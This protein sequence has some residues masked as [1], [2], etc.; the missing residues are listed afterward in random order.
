MNT[1]IVF[2]ESEIS[3]FFSKEVDSSDFDVLYEKNIY[4]SKGL[5][6]FSRFFAFFSKPK[7]SK[8]RVF[9]FSIE[10]ILVIDLV[11]RKIGCPVV[12]L[13]NPIASMSFKNKILFLLYVKVKSIE[14][15][16]FDKSDSIKYNFN[17]HPQI[18]SSKLIYLAS[19]N[20]RNSK[21]FFSGV[22]KGR[23]S[24]LKKIKKDLGE[25]EVDFHIVKD[26]KRRYSDEDISFLTKDY[27]SFSDYLN[28]VFDS[29]ILVDVSQ[30]QQ[31]GVTLRVIEAFLLDKKL[32][33]T[34]AEVVDLVG[35]RKENV[36]I[37]GQDSRSLS[38]F[39]KEDYIPLLKDEKSIY[40]F[41]RLI[42]VVFP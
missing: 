19:R 21:A 6:F 13:W 1:K 3:H 27:I 26:K 40:T 23:L 28:R 25:V 12:W 37:Y 34:N 14:V 38:S 33:T 41:S 20:Q 24:L 4:Q 9:I 2:K 39:L 36:Y 22:D 17:Y 30:N 8:E 5:K 16:T 11:F 35:Y 32:I 15:W 29:S 7:S 31:S 10:N 18:H 42:R